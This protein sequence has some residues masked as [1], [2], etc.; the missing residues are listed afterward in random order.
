MQVFGSTG[1]VPELSDV[2]GSNFRFM[3]AAGLVSTPLA[4]IEPFSSNDGKVP[5]VG[6]TKSGTLASA[7]S[8]ES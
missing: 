8:G 4:K 3:I 6:S 1:N 2:F 5:F 7:S